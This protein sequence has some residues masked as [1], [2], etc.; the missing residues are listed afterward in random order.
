MDSDFLCLFLLDWH[1][2]FSNSQLITQ[3]RREQELQ[4]VLEDCNTKKKKAED[5]DKDVMNEVYKTHESIHLT[6]VAGGKR[7]PEMSGRQCAVHQFH[8]QFGR[9]SLEV[10]GR[11]S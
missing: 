8:V 1:G 2:F 6:T 5:Q 3:Q 9:W 4:I 11:Q 10:G 7:S